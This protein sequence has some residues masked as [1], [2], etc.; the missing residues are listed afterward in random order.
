MLKVNPFILGL[1]LLIASFI[2]YGNSIF[3]GFVWDDDFLI[4]RNP[5]IKDIKFAKKMFSSDVGEVATHRVTLGH[6]RPISMLLFMLDYKLWGL[7]AGPYHLVN[8]LIHAV[9]SILLFALFFS[10]SRE[11]LVSFI[12]ALLF[13]LHPIHTEA[14]TPIHNRMGIWV[15]LLMLISLLFYLRA[16]RQKS[17]LCLFMSVMFFLLALFSKE[18]AIMFV[19]ILLC[20]DY[21]FTAEQR[22]II[23]LKKFG[24]YLPY[25]IVILLYL[26]L[27]KNF[28]SQGLALGKWSNPIF[29]SLPFYLQILTTFKIITAYLRLLV[30]PVNLSA[31]YIVQVASIDSASVMSLLL[32][33]ALLLSAYFLRRRN[34]IISFSISFFFVTILPFS[35]LIPFGVRFNER[36]LYLPSAAFCFIVGYSFQRLWM[37]K[38]HRFFNLIG[39]KTLII[40]GLCSLLL[41]Y[42][43]QT[44]KRNYDWRTNLLLWQRTVAS[45]PAWAGGH[46]N[47]GYA[48]MDIQQYDKALRQFQTAI[49][50]KPNEYRSYL[51]IGKVLLATRQFKESLVYL[52]KA[53]L[54]SKN[55]AAVYNDLGIA[56]SYLADFD[57]ALA[58]FNKALSIW[59]EFPEPYHNIGIL[60]YNKGEWR[61]AKD[62]FEKAFNLNPDNLIF[63]YRLEEVSQKIKNYG[64]KDMS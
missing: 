43:Y 51:G 34:R 58:S 36:L 60:Y 22:A 54:L 17:I 12:S 42:G 2:V 52:K 38:E 44:L 49:F 30:F 50:L 21:F 9:N 4:V 40:I 28:I 29:S 35:L 19:F 18:T 15:C 1:L 56:Y 55:N 26:L 32:V 41:F 16:N 64:Q 10:L 8:I 37:V 3:N 62:Y 27:R 20:Y 39:H 45:C 7:R 59:K 48:Y 25:F 61:D 33:S 24:L 13:A 47:L 63:K 11:K 6:Y 46:I 14:V 53:K 31:A 5:Y 23:I 57:M